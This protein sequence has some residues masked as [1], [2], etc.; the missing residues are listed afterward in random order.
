MARIGRA[1]RAELQR[2]AQQIRRAGQ[3]AGW[4]TDRIT[5]SI[6]SELPDVL[7]LEAW[8]L[9]FG[10]SRPQA[11]TE[12]IALYGADS[13]AAPP[14]NSSML[15]RWEHGEFP[16]GPEYGQMLCRL[17]RADPA[18][19][20]LPANAVLM[21]VPDRATE[22]PRL[23][24]TIAA[25]GYRMTAE[26]DAATLAALRESIQLAL[27]AEG[28]VGGPLVT[29]QLEA[30]VSYYSLNY[31]AF[32]PGLLATEV[33]RTRALAGAMLREDQPDDARTE[34]RRLA[35][36][37]SALVGNTAFHLAD[38]PAAQI[39]FATAARL[40]T[41]TGD[42]HLICWALGAQ[43]LTGYTLRRYAEALDLARQA[44]DYAGTPL[45]RAQILAWSQL[46]SLALLGTQYRSDAARVIAAAQEEMAADPDGEQPGRFGFDLAELHLHI[47]EA[48]LLLGDHAR[49]RTHAQASRDEVRPGRPAW[50][51]ATLTL[52][53]GEAARRHVSDAAA[54][55]LDVL[56]TIPPPAL[57]E[58]SRVRL[59]AL[60]HEFFTTGDPGTEARD[61]RERLRALPV[62][63]PAGRI[64]VEP[65]GPRNFRE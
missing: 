65:N 64:S 2:R 43:A 63:V 17:Y 8:R 54:L 34:L 48:T 33:H 50:A 1:R 15:C 30:A 12:I 9:A 39:H 35:G 26:D 57:R 41:S 27:E 7:P 56:D 58:T 38:Y 32:P 28:P 37:L 29:G 59:R 47:A 44:L 53:R 46:R 6:R 4:N 42:S 51:A 13:L 45:R 49:A 11:I 5:A 40:G 36:W 60:D 14:L 62:L 18:Q 20:G 61:L 10:W 24:G 23:Q 22:Y 55:A 25:N 21:A 19:L 31:S 52:A 16:P 3:R